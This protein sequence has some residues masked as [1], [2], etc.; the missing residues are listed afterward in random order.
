MLAERV[1]RENAYDAEMAIVELLQLMDLGTNGGIYLHVC[2]GG[3][4]C[5]PLPGKGE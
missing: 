1:L 3:T 4:K 2:V 5:P